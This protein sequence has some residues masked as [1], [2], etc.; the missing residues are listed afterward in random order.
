MLYAL[1]VG[2]GQDP[3]NEDELPFVYEKEPESA[4]DHGRGARPSRLL[5]ARSRHRHRLGAGSSTA[6][7]ACGCTSRSKARTRSSAAS[8]SSRSSTKAPA[9]ARWC[10][11]ERKVS[12]KAT[13]EPIATV[14]QTTFCRA[15]GG[16]GGPPRQPPGAASD[17]DARARRSLRFRH[18]SGDGVDL[19]AQS[20][21]AIR[22]T[23]S[24]PSPSRPA[25]R[26]RSCTGSA[27][28]ASPATR[29]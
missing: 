22:C 16:F 21:T 23:P 26:G 28:S 3:M 20:A 14:T 24:P 15:D 9:R 11:T 19:S 25:T 6:S 8:A 7:R 13:G 10:L 18:A 17:P 2:L 4:A 1:G 29:C 5:D 27:I 12:D